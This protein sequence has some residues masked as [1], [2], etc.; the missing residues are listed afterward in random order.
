MS[1]INTLLWWQWL[2]IGAV[3]VGIVLLYFLKLRR[4]PLE[5]PSTYLWQ[6]TIEDLHVNT[7]WQRLRRN[8]LLFLQVLLIIL[9]M[10]AL[11]RPG[12]RG[13]ELTDE[14]F[15]FMID[16]SASMSATDQRPDRL[17]IAKEKTID[18][19]S[20]M[21]AGNSAMVIAFSDQPQVVQTY[22]ES[23]KALRRQIEAIKPTA[24]PTNLRGAL[25]AAAG[26]ANPGLTRLEN[27]QVVDESLPATLYIFSDGGFRSVPEFSLGNLTPVFVPIGQPGAEN[28]G[29]VA[30]STDRNPEDPQRM[31]AFCSVANC[32]S[33]PA[34]VLLELFIS[35]V[36]VD[37]VE[38][39]VEPGKE[40]GWHFDL[41]DLN[42]AS[43]RLE[44]QHDDPFQLDNMAYSAVNRPRR[45]HVLLVTPGDETLETALRTDKITELAVVDV[46]SPSLLE[47]EQH[48]RRAE[49][50]EYDLII[51]DRCRPE[52]LPQANTLFIGTLPP[53][54]RW[55]SS[56]LE[57]PPVVVDIDYAHPLTQ[58]IQMNNVVIAEGVQLKP[59]TGSTNLFDSQYGPLLSIGPREGLE[60]AVLGFPLLTSEDGQW[61][62]NTTWPLR[63]S[64]PVFVYNVIRYLGGSR[65]SSGVTSV[66]P[67]EP[68]ALRS[69]MSAENLQVVDPDGRSYEVRRDAQKTFVF[70]RTEK[71]GVYLV[72]QP[73]SD[74]TQRF[75]VNLFDLRE[76]NIAPR[77][78]VE[79][80][81]ETVP[82][83]RG[84]QTK[85][86]ELWKWILLVGFAI[87]ALEWYIYN[88]RVYV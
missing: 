63:P 14:R 84:L 54:D 49:T 82:G 9:L 7:I 4:H 27:D 3:P 66:R 58:L 59:P 88:R 29:I 30:F 21:R 71:P 28:V 11:L 67:G 57:A 77:A 16:N 32:G 6:R 42:E 75:V 76:S 41:P 68:I 23:R 47:K 46:A 86:R 38:L 50:G 64:F 69:T 73:G 85:R 26:L 65:G 74:F 35:E 55:T 10:L 51:Y 34:T 60:D 19:V 1:I 43:L 45:S 70:T 36:S 17:S 62:P 2:I 56:D 48:R 33:E 37:L 25:R 80:G 31:Q 53:D 39:S 78:E 44:M 81:Y 15:V 83:T 13:T 61:V 8:V 52:K 12:W 72:Q 24:R 18:L 5:V 87:L 79:L 40:Q 20:Q 22:T